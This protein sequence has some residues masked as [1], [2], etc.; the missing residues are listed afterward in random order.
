[1]TDGDISQ[2]S[3]LSS[4]V[5]KGLTPH[6]P[7]PPHPLTPSPLTRPRSS[8]TQLDVVARRLLLRHV[9]I[10]SS[11]PPPLRTLSKHLV[12]TA[13]RTIGRQYV[14]GRKKYNPPTWENRSSFQSELD[15]DEISGD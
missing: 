10:M 4:A 6:P 9:V 12:K 3:S 11:F 14:S 5:E 1:M 13:K 7:H 2:T 8:L 15:E